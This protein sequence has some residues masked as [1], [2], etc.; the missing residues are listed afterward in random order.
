MSNTG[1]IERESEIGSRLCFCCLASGSKGNALYVSDGETAILIDAGLSGADMER[2]FASKG[3]NPENLD[4]IIVSHE[5]IDHVRGVGVLSRRYD[6]PVYATAKTASAA[7][8][9]IKK[10]NVCKTFS[11]GRSFSINRLAIHP[12]SISHD[13]E[14][15]AG[16]TVRHE[17][18]KIGLA[19]DLGL[20]T[21]LVKEHLK[22]CAL[23]MI[24]ANHDLDM[25]ENGPYPWPL[26]QRIKSRSG[27]LSNADSKDLL[28]E[29]KHPHLK[30]VI[31][32]HLSEINNRPEKALA[33]VGSALEGYG[34]RLEVAVQDTCGDLIFLT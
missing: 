7:A 15:P 29:I 6:I 21:K 4:A 16:F 11:C 31:L 25:L 24:E 13:A 10:V 2:R 32:G 22:E 9:I 5:H 14:D 20:A 12:F 19:T 26:K 27:H 3:L 17:D 18:I 28:N 8:P 30:Q 1:K 34:A 23:L 33:H